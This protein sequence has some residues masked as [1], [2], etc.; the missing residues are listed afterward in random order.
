MLL[1]FLRL[2][3][4]IASLVVIRIVFQFLMQGV[5]TMLPKHRR[6]RKAA[7]RFRMPLYPLPALIAIAGFL[8]ILF[9]RKR[10]FAEMELAAAVAVSGL[11]VYFLRERWRKA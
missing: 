5:A 1:C 11:I 9:S 6:E 4:V 3:E 10:F 2:Q 8:F 7:G